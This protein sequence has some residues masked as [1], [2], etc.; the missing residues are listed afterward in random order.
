[1]SLATDKT[2]I[3]V[4]GMC[5]SQYKRNNDGERK[6]R[7]KRVTQKIKGEKREPKSFLIFAARA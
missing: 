1:M 4:T 2:L 5:E 6:K 7:R 3:G